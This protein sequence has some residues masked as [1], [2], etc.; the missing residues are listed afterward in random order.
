MKE[1]PDSLT[2]GA[3]G[4]VCLFVLVA[5]ISLYNTR[6]LYR[7]AQWV[8]HSH[9]VLDELAELKQ[10]VFVAQSRG[11]DDPDDGAAGG[12]AMQGALDA[13]GRHAVSI[14]HLT[15]DNSH[16][17][18]KVVEIQQQI[19]EFARLLNQIAATERTQG[20]DAARQLARAMPWQSTR[21]RLV[22]LIDEMEQ[23]ERGLLATRM[24][25]NHRAYTL[26]IVLGLVAGATGLAA[27]CLFAWLLG[28]HLRTQ[29]ES[30][31]KLESQRQFLHATL[32]GIGDGVVVTDELCRVTFL[33]PVAEE[34]TGWAL[35]EANGQ[36]IETVFHIVNESTRQV[37]PSPARQAL[38]T[39]HII[40]LA[41]HTIL[42]AKSGEEFCIDDSA[43]PIRDLQGEITGVVLV[44]RDVSDQRRADSALREN[45]RRKDEFLAMLGHELRNPL[46]GIVTGVQVL[47]MLKLGGDA[48]EMAAII[49]RQAA[50]MSH[51][52]DDL[53]DVSRIARGKLALRRAP[54]EVVELLETIVLDYQKSHIIEDCEVRFV[55]PDFNAW[56]VGDRTRL[57]QVVTNL[58]HNGC[59]FCDGPNTVT[60]SLAL[61]QA[62]EQV[63]IAVHDCG[64]GMTC[65]TI[66][67]IFEPFNQADNSV[68]RSR[69][70]LGLGL[71]LVKGVVD[72]HG[73]SI[74]AESEGLG[75]GTR[76]ILS[77]PLVARPTDDEPSGENPSSALRKVLLI[78][79]RRDAI[80]PVQKFLE[81]V[82][83]QVETA[84][85]GP[86]GIATAG[87]FRPDVILCDI[88]LE[89]PINGYE[90]AKLVRESKELAETYLVAVTGYGQEEDRRTA[91]AA[92][93][94][95]HLTK[96]VSRDQ[97]Q[98]V[99]ARMPRF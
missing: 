39:A 31:A 75:K 89:G 56:V 92:G 14:G 60:V 72:L 12:D 26:A 66:Q 87:E 59:K 85:D 71:A 57:A 49:G 41:N 78:D 37:V 7:D 94:D 67:R 70:G 54:L 22:S 58:L 3:I 10:S 62:D 98:E 42:I 15:E 21:T 13:M 24:Q 2:W 6:E 11:W 34:L 33:N 52:V 95:Y 91:Q 73:G 28:R 64:I 18:A 96:P 90:V 36:P 82:G 5:G 1:K 32:T 81:M 38:D 9:Q 99:M 23:H 93:F 29:A 35:P 45:E 77:L 86:K 83:H 53:L 19:P 25:T 51:I 84:S 79:D 88:G 17:Q 8:S 97:L 48:G 40:G 50:H 68:E 74:R 76:F 65:E 43:A 80:W 16:Q 61:R 27:C 44:F 47:E 63:D 69:G 20:I 4:V 30:A 55:P 46:A